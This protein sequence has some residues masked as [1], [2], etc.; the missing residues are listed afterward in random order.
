M[1]RYQPLEHS[2]ILQSDGSF[3]DDLDESLS[4]QCMTD[5]VGN[6]DGGSSKLPCVVT[7][8]CWKTMTEKF[9]GG[10]HLTHQALF[11]MLAEKHG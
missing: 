3:A 5:I 7:D 9:K 10:Y 6:Q 4:D 1:M 2:L 11:M 8:N